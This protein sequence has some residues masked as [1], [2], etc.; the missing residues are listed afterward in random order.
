MVLSTSE[1]APTAVVAGV[2]STINQNLQQNEIGGIKQSR[3][4]FQITPAVLNRSAPHQLLLAV[5]ASQSLHS[6]SVPAPFLQSYDWAIGRHVSRQALARNNVIVNNTAPDGTSVR[7]ANITLMKQSPDGMWLATAEEW[8]PT[9]PNRFCEFDGQAQRRETYLKFWR[10]DVKNGRWCLETRIDSPHQSEYL[11][12]ANRILDIN[13]DPSKESFASIGQDGLL[14]IWSPKTRL[15]DGR[16]VKGVNKIGITTWVCSQIVPIG[17]SIES[18]QLDGRGPSDGPPQTAKLSFSDDGSVLAV[19]LDDSNALALGMVHF[20]DVSTGSIKA[21]QPLVY[22]N[23]L[24][25]LHFLG[26]YL[27]VLSTELR[28]W[29]VVSN[30]LVYGYVLKQPSIPSHWRDGIYQ[31]A[32]SRKSS[33]FIISTPVMHSNNNLNSRIAI[34]DPS[35][36]DPYLIE[37]LPYIATALIPLPDNVGFGVIDNEAEIRLVKP[38]TASVIDPVQLGLA[39]EVE[40]L[41]EVT[42]D[43]GMERIKIGEGVDETMAEVDGD[44]ED[45]DDEQEHEQEQEHRP[46]VR[47]HQLAEVFESSTSFALPPVQDLFR[48]VASLYIG[49]SSK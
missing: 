46:V 19:S 3:K 34:F 15:A 8:T 44:S 17:R 26:R 28:V 7:E 36:P 47:S 40:P 31:L 22:G 27:V 11:P 41:D 39:M 37:E 1:L 4:P 6:E 9:I 23:G 10:W 16:I 20:V 24:S 12:W 2:Q 21:S 29:D 45:E 30:K 48:A 43:N 33:R 38:N 5:P 13:A 42:M 18:S 32:A 14:R 25:G 49:K 35:S